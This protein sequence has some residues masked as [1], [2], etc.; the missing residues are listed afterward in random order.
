MK[1]KAKNS[2][3]K[4]TNSSVN[5]SSG[6]DISMLNISGK[7]ARDDTEMFVTSVGVGKKKHFCMYC[8]TFQSKIVRHLERVHGN[9]L[10]IQK[11]KDL[12]KGTAER[13]KIIETIRRR[14]DFYFNVDCAR[15][16]G[17]LLVERRSKKKNT[18]DYLLIMLYVQNVKLSF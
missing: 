18:T 14:G 5:T 9:E 1:K 7:C 13:K 10:E 12:P 11:F 17:E 6:L 15:N 2:L 16:D 8:N 3:T 4:E